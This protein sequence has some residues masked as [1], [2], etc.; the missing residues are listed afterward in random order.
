M[1]LTS[2]QLVVTDRENGL[3]QP[4]PE[5]KHQR[6]LHQAVYKGEFVHVQYIVVFES[7]LAMLGVCSKGVR[8]RLVAC[9]LQIHRLDFFLQMMFGT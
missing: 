2:Q 5:R 3:Q 1:Q 7:T 8:W 6:K 4:V 9:L